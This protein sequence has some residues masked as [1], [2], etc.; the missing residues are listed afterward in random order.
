MLTVRKYFERIKSEPKKFRFLTSRVLRFCHP[1]SQLLLIDRRRYKLRS[2]PTTLSTTLWYNPNARMREEDLIAEILQEGDVFVDVGANIGTHSLVAAHSVG[3]KGTVYSVEANPRIAKFLSMN[4]GL[5]K[6]SNVEIV[7]SAVGD[8]KGIISFSDGFLDDVNRPTSDGSG[9]AVP[10]RKLDDIVPNIPVRLLKID[11]EG[12]EFQV[13]SGAKTVLQNTSIILFEANPRR[14]TDFSGNIQQ[15]FQ[16]L[17]DAGFRIFKLI[18][19]N[20]ELAPCDFL[21]SEGQDL[22]AIKPGVWDK[23]C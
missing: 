18:G 11:V 21:P 5:N 8:C 22:L 19:N 15:I 3:E 10:M 14:V 4:V 20:V 7:N 13:L 12:Y 9:V 2:F 6:F 17:R 1:F 16:I 23:F